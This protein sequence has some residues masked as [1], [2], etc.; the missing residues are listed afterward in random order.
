VTRETAARARSVAGALL[1]CVLL[2]S[3]VL[4][5]GC[6]TTQLGM[7]RSG[8]DSL[9]AQVD[10]LTV[11]DSVTARV[12]ADVREELGAQR[13]LLLSAQARQAST[14]RELADLMGRLDGRLEEITSRFTR[15]SERAGGAIQRL[16]V[17]VS[18]PPD[19]GTPPAGAAAPATGTGSAPPA[20]AVVPSPS[21]LFDVATRDLTEGRYPLALQ[22]YREFLRRYPDTELA[23]N[24]QYGVGE[25][26]FAQA[27]FD[28]AAAEYAKVDAQWPKGDRAPA[29]L[30]KLALSQERLGRTADARKTFEDL[31]R[32]FPSSSEAG[33]AR[34]RIGATKH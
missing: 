3:S 29:A 26:F 28:S 5:P 10:T 6:Y 32:R 11:R 24:A 20:G 13:D 23:D 14:Q 18:S 22:G 17:T 2:G 21:Q 4:T 27:V 33:L 15:V 31:I 34:D 7:L 19:A 9:R 1:A 30:Y 25:C 16:P 8:L 12:V